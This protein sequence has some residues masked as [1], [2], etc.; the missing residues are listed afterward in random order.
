[1]RNALLM[2][3][4]ILTGCGGDTGGASDCT[5][6][7]GGAQCCVDL[8]PLPE[9]IVCPEGSTKSVNAVTGSIRCYAEVDGSRVKVGPFLS[10]RSEGS[11]SNFGNHEVG[12][13]VY[14]C[15]A[16]TGLVVTRGII[17]EDS[18]LSCQVECFDSEGLLEPCA[19]PCQE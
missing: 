9:D 8:A 11:M 2:G 10:M 1:M 3:V 4:L 15:D 14:T 6:V 7:E 16:N 5:P 12:G 17:T 19:Y 13:D 18:G